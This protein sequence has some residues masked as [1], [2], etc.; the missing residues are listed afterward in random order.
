[1][2]IGPNQIYI[3][4]NGNLVDVPAVSIMKIILT[5]FIL[6]TERIITIEDSAELKLKQEYT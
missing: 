1:M 5:N 2:V 4:Q 6:S 3:E